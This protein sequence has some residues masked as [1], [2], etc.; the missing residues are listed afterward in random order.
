MATLLSEDIARSP[1]LDR[2]AHRQNQTEGLFLIAAKFISFHVSFFARPQ[3]L[4]H[5]LLDPLL[6]MQSLK[7]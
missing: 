4:A 2:P 6:S 7:I 5:K 1:D 3:I